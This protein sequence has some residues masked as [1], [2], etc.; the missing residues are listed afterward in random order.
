LF[1]H[2]VIDNYSRKLPAWELAT[3]LDPTTT[4]RVL[5]AADRHQSVA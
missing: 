2:G 4:C 5:K 3:K 1:L